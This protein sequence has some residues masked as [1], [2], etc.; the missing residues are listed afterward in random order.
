MTSLLADKLPI[1]GEQEIAFDG[2]YYGTTNSGRSSLRWAL[3]SMDLYAKRILV[4]DF[5]CQVVIDVLLEFSIQP[6]FY[7]VGLDLDFK[8]PTDARNCDALYLVKYFGHSSKSFSIALEQSNI[9]LIIDTVFDAE[10]PTVKTNSHWCAFNSLRKISRIA[11]YSQLASNKPLIPIERTRLE[12][13][14]RLKYQ[15]KNIK[16]QFLTKKIESEEHYLNLFSDAESILDDSKGVYYPEDNS[17]F[18]SNIFHHNLS[19][20]TELRRSNFEMAKAT[21]S[22]VTYIDINPYLP[23]FLPILLKDRDRVREKLRESH[24]YLAIHWPSL[25]TLGNKL[26]PNILSIPLDSRY[27]MSDIQRMCQIIAKEAL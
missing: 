11:D 14:S 10:L 2:L 27:Q 7:E 1:G 20:E 16:H 23:S 5:V 9:P 17:I 12:T 15:A 4:P 18:L 3:H 19:A 21:L 8:L 22:D 24:I 6:V 13:F 25:S 26:S